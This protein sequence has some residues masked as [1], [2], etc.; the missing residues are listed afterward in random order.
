MTPVDSIKDVVRST[1]KVPEF[2]KHLKKAG[3][4]IGRNVGEIIMKTWKR[5]ALSSGSISRQ[6]LRLKAATL[7]R[8]QLY[9]I[10]KLA[11]LIFQEKF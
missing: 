4:Y 2:D 7:N 1:V 11:E 10:I 8:C 3:G 9:Y 6:R 5:H